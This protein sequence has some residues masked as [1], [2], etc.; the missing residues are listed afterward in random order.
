MGE[1][2]NFHF[3]SSGSGS[4]VCKVCG[5]IGVYSGV[6]SGIKSSICTEG[7][8][9]PAGRVTAI[10]GKPNNHRQTGQNKGCHKNTAIQKMAERTNTGHGVITHNVASVSNKK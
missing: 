2:L 4:G 7:V 1:R 10:R 3:Y 8:V 6:Y 5:E 9:M